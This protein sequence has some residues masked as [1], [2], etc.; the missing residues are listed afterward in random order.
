MTLQK[1]EQRLYDYLLQNSEHK[2]FKIGTKKELATS[3]GVSSS[4][5]TKKLDSLQEKELI[6]VESKQGRN[7]GLVIVLNQVEENTLTKEDNIIQSNKEYAK[8]LREEYYPTY[9]YQPKTNIKRRTKVE[10]IEFNSI[11]DERKKMF[12]EMNFRLDK[13]PYP[14]KDI[15]DYSND[16]EGY[17]KAY[18]LAKTYDKLCQV[19]MRVLKRKALE[20]ADKCEDEKESNFYYTQAKKYET[21]ETQ[22]S[23]RQILGNKFFG[24]PVFNTFYKLYKAS[25]NFSNFNMFKYLTHV[26]HNVSFFNQAG[27]NYPI[28]P[29]PNYFV[30]D[31][32]LDSYQKYFNSIKEAL[33]SDNRQLSNYTMRMNFN[34]EYS[35]DLVLQQ[36][37]VLYL[38]DY[39][40]L[41]YDLDEVFNV[42]LDVEDYELGFVNEK[43]VTLME[44]KNNVEKETQDFDDYDKEI[45]NKFNK[46]LIINDYAPKTIT[47]M[48]RLSMFPMQRA[49]VL[50]NF[51][52][53]GYKSLNYKQVEEIGLICSNSELKTIET[54][55]TDFETNVRLGKI[56]IEVSKNTRDYYITRMFGHFTGIDINIRDIKYILEKYNKKDLIPLTQNG[57]LD[58]EVIKGGYNNNE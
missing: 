58:Y 11:K 33:N 21:K 52:L 23:Y 4:T 26:F 31:K 7:G 40:E 55:Q 48:Y 30:S 45:I 24:T 14:T 47:N 53:D 9:Y 57:M 10:M 27:Y 56:Y 25:L 13:T 36:L 8:R 28:I 42:A 20:K 22:F 29:Q 18:I 41:E 16:P 43:Q 2:H 50:D 3:I 44:Y 39:N 46:Q 19:H 12:N 5:L 1:N 49:Y 32:Y 6:I 34:E 35:N 15:F 37:K 51:K 17:F 54:G 38:K